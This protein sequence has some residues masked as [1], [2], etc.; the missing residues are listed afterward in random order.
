[1]VDGDT[2]HVELG[3]RDV[4]VRFIG[5]DTP[6]SVQPGSAV[7][8]FGR[9]ASEYTRRR[10]DGA[11]VD[12]EYDLERIDPYGRTLAYVWVGDE[13]FNRALV[14]EGYATVT[15]YPPNVRYV[16]EFTEAQREARRAGLGL[17][18]SC[19]SA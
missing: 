8:C 11:V 14:A 4:T 3:G 16:D 9:R 18:G 7:E 10:L 2:A 19:P 12:L 13:L 15:T 6:E 1:V 17:W 5:I